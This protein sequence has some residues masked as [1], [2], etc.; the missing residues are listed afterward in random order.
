MGKYK[1][2]IC[3]DEFY[4]EELDGLFMHVVYGHNIAPNHVMRNV[5]P[6]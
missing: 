1:C 5:V 3:G 6:I 4:T 2:K